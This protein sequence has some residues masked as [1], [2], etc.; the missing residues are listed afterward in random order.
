MAKSSSFPLI[1]ILVVLFCS[2][3]ILQARKIL[4]LKKAEVS[5]S[6]EESL[7]FA[8]L[9]DDECHASVNNNGRLLFNLHLPSTNHRMLPESVPSP[10][11]GHS[12]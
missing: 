5:L 7:D 8:S 1:F 3:P 2:T 9:S 10:G 11:I 4:S 12:H 6:M